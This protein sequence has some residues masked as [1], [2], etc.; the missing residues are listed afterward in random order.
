MYTI[1]PA[2][3]TEHKQAEVCIIH[4]SQHKWYC[5]SYAKAI[6]LRRQWY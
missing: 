3:S 6:P 1:P 4:F 5:I 2:F